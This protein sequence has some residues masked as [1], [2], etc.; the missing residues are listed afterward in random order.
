MV[1]HPKTL[2]PKVDLFFAPC[3]GLTPSEDYQSS[4]PHHPS[5]ARNGTA[6]LGRDGT[7]RSVSRDA[8]HTR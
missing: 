5:K 8:S 2:F 7:A 4:I 3:L 6:D 1:A